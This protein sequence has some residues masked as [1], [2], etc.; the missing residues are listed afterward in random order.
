MP[1]PPYQQTPVLETERL[2]LRGYQLADLDAY[3][4][5][6]QAPAFYRYLSPRPMVEE[7]VWTMMLRSVGHWALQGFGF[8]AVEE[9]ASG[10]FIGAVGFADGKRHIEPS[11][12]GVPEIGWVL[13]AAAHGQGYASEAVA[14]ALA[15]GDQHFGG[16]RTVCI[17]DPDN[18]ASRRVAEKFGY[19]EFART[20]YKGEP[21]LM[22]E[23]PARSVTF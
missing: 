12:K 23:R 5:I 18:L 1:A 7:E 19:R 14:A 21:T 6:W 20:T 4:A 13:A 10:R 17:M 8:W 11:I 22:M 2:C 3:L 16:A 15:W 9:K